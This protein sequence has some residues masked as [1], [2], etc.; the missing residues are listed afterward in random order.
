MRAL[1]QGPQEFENIAG[2]KVADGI[3]E[4]FLSAS[5]EF[6]DRVQNGRQPDPWLFGFGVI[7]KTDSMLIGMGGFPGPPD[8]N[9]VVEI[10]YGIAPTYQGNGYAT[11]VAM[12]LVDFASRDARVKTIARIRLPSGT[13]PLASWKNAASKKQAKQSIRKII[14]RSGD[15]RNP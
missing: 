7:H 12:T 10:A 2:L 8:S 4:Q 11:E 3:R 14:C 6:I 9:G 13:L 5:S 1:L 15:G